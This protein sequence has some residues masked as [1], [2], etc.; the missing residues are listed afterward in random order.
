[1]PFNQEQLKLL[2]KEIKSLGIFATASEVDAVAKRIADRSSNPNKSDFSISTAIRGIMAR[3]GRCVNESTRTE[4]LNYCEKALATGATPGSYLVPTIQANDIIQILSTNGIL[5]AIGPRVWPMPGIQKLTVPTATG[6]PTVAWLGQNTAQSAADPNLG[7]VSFDLKTCRSLSVIPNE[8]LR[9][10]VPALDAIIT[11]LIGIAFAEAQDQAAFSS[12][13][14]TNGPTALMQAASIATINAAGGSANG[15]N[16]TYQDLLSVLAKAATNKAKPPYCWVMSPRTFF[17][18]VA[19]LLDNQ[20]RPVFLP[21]YAGLQNAEMNPGVSTPVGKL[22]GW[23][24]FV[25]PFIAENE[26]VGSGSNQSHIIFCNPRY[27]HVAED[28][29]LEI[30]ISTERYFELN[31]CGVR[32][33]SRL[34]LGYAPPQGITVLQGVN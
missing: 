29:N 4:D 3:S 6:L 19:G 31:Q 30:M 24:V 12:T 26:S 10:S 2:V 34:D 7:Q 21:G 20:S 22:F 17:Q 28:Q 23:P 5:R 14:V 32:G 15:G 18:R 1:M 9:V 27:V 25:T 11:E 16:L 8:L 33:V 13:T